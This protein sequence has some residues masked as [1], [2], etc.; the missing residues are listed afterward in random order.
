MHNK[1]L[2]FYLPHLK[3][4]KAKVCLNRVVTGG[5]M[6]IRYVEQKPCQYVQR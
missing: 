4:A 6:N 3:D 1:G 2:S 5:L